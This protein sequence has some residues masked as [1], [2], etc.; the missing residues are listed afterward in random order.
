[1]T[2]SQEFLFLYKNERN[3]IYSFQSRKRFFMKTTYHTL[4]FLIFT[5]ITTLLIT[6]NKK[7]KIILNQQHQLFSLIS[8][9]IFLTI[10]GVIITLEQIRFM[11]GINYIAAFLLA[12]SLGFLIAVE[13]S[14]YTL[15]TNINSIFIS[16]IVAIVI[17]GIAFNMKHDVT[18]YMNQLIM[19]TFTF[20]IMACL[21]FFLSQKIDTTFLRHLYALGGFLLSCAYIAIDTQ[22]ISI[23]NRYNQLATNEYVLGGVQIYFPKQVK[24]FGNSTR[25]AAR[26]TTVRMC[27]NKPKTGGTGTIREAGGAFADMGKA[28][29][30]QF[31]Y[32]LQKEQLKKMHQHLEEEIK[33]H[34]KQAE[35]HQAAIKRHEEKL[36]ELR[37]AAGEYKE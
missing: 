7:W 8:L 21:L 34:K 36:K 30:D 11:R 2:S 5:I 18:I 20:M 28:K 3:I 29:E 19:L 25:T 16:C 22:S 12:I 31:F 13:A 14:W 1:M 10:Y 15:E 6:M 27:S 9:V 33:N 37:A 35:E 4:V 32:N 17:S 23:K 24:M 26:M